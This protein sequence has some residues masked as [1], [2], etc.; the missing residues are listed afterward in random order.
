MAREF[1]FIHHYSP[2]S[3]IRNNNVIV[4]R[5]VN[6]PILLCE[7]EVGVIYDKVRRLLN[8]IETWLEYSLD[9]AIK[10]ETVQALHISTNKTLAVATKDIEELINHHQ[11]T[12]KDDVDT[13]TDVAV[14]LQEIA[15]DIFKS[16]IMQ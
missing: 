4:I 13:L 14:Q 8:T 12:N 16:Y 10:N 3:R 9:D 15:D 7:K 1:E 6:S 2:K 5:Q 11:L